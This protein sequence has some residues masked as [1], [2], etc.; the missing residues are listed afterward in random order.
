[1]EVRNFIEKR[2]PFFHIMKIIK[3]LFSK[4]EICLFLTNIILEGIFIVVLWTSFLD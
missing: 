4:K 2:V 3:K 1:M